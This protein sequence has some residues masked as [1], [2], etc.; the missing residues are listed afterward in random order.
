M[1][2]DVC[3]DALVDSAK[4]LPLLFV[5]Y[6]LIEWLELKW[7]NRLGRFMART[8]TTGPVLGAAAG[9]IPQCGISVIASA[10]YTQRLI[11]IGTLFA[12]FLATSDEA[13]PVI[14]SQPDHAE[15]LVPLL[16]SKF[17]LAVVLGYL[18]DLIF[19][20]RNVR[21]LAHIDNY[22]VGHDDEGH[23]HESVF[24]EKGCCGHTPGAEDHK[25]ESLIKRLLVHP[26]VHT[27]KIFVFIF[28][29]SLVL[30]LH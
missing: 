9:I 17:V 16:L 8:G 14:L 6:F 15:V 12:V 18:I 4:M 27:L 23:H 1:F 10:L 19:R 5:I 11:T 26:L 30:G 2:L 22:R 3:L 29:I 7:G 21:V 24:E 25:G 13:I 28:V 20:K